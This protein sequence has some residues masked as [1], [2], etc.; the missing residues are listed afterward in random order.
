MKMK[1]QHI[2]IWDTA[3]SVLRR[4]FTTLNTY[5]IKERKSE[6]SNPSSFPETGKKE[7][8]INPNQAEGRKNKGKSRNQWN[9]KQRQQR[10]MMEQKVV[11]SKV[12]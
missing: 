12:Q 2:K 1:I 3:K 9:S 10:K 8:K 5:I 6:I 11:L 7:S 4:K